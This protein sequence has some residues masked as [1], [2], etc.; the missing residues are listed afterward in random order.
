MIT[1]LFKSERYFISNAMTTR[2]IP[3]CKRNGEESGLDEIY[4][5]NRQVVLEEQENWMIMEGPH[6][7]RGGFTLVL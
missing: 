1:E 4:S 7:K 2:K 3:T 6:K 5:T